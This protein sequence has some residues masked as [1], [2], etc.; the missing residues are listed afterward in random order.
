MTDG[1]KMR[2]LKPEKQQGAENENGT[3]KVES[4]IWIRQE[5]AAKMLRSRSKE[6]G[7]C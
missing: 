4:D 3:G 2:E 7:H 1:F 5:K 6:F